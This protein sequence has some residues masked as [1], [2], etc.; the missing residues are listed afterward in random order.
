MK[1][2]EDGQG[3]KSLRPGDIKY[4][5][6]N[7]DGVLDWKDQQQ[8]GEGNM[9]HWMA[10]INAAV[11][12]KNFDFSALFQGAF[13]Y[14]TYV[15]IQPSDIM[16]KLRWTESNNKANASVPRLGGSTTNGFVSDFYYKKA[17]YIRLKVV[18]I[19]Y[20]LP[21][22]ILSKVRISQLRVYIAGTNL[23]TIDR[24]KKYGIDPE[25]PSGLGGYYYPQQKTISAGLNISF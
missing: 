14:Y 13:G 6:M 12:Y 17:G 18:S 15:F 25:S 24:L 4:K 7:G 1:F 19:G 5:D 11:R 20:S 21:S 3:N 16:Y 10:G 22:S 9:P 8:I 2:V 23:I